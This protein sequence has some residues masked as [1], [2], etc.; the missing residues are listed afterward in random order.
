MNNR[1]WNSQNPN[2]GEFKRVL[3]VCSAGLLRSP[4]TALVL[5]SEPYNYNTRAAGLVE[6]FAL[7]PV[8]DVLLNWAQCVITMDYTQAEEMA[9]R[10]DGP[11]YNFNI[12]DTYPYRDPELV[13][14]IKGRAENMNEYL[15]QG[16]LG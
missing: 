10:Y 6:D 3:C 14:I 11:I 2:Q 12:P 5:A 8:D 4:T 1:M 9:E 7:I 15:F 16:E 13:R